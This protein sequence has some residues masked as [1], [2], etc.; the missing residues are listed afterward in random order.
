MIFSPFGRIRPYFIIVLKPVT[1]L[2]LKAR[3]LSD[4]YF[5]TDAFYGTGCFP[6]LSSESVISF[7]LF[8]PPPP[9]FAFEVWKPFQ[10]CGAGFAEHPLFLQQS[11]S[12]HFESWKGSKN[13][14]NTESIRIFKE[15]D[16]LCY[17]HDES[18]IHNCS[19]YILILRESWVTCLRR[20]HGFPQLIVIS[21]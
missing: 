15:D 8:F 9:A 16:K 6:S 11:P 7:T 14:A 20:G 2:L 18:Y 21:W 12:S 10:E 1:A 3:H 19:V 4:I 17:H 13:Q 5:D